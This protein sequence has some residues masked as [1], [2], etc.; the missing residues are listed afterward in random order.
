MSD[1]E[2][3]RAII[4]HNN[5]QGAVLCNTC[6]V[7]IKTGFDHSDAHHFCDMKCLKEFKEDEDVDN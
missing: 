1:K 3:T 5:G 6:G 7:I 4:K 2:Y